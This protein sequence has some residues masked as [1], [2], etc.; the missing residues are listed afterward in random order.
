MGSDGRIGTVGPD[1]AVFFLSVIDEN[2]CRSAESEGRCARD[3]VDETPTGQ[4]L[5]S[6]YMQ[7]MCGREM[8]IRDQ[9]VSQQKRI[10]IWVGDMAR[11]NPALRRPHLRSR[12]HRLASMFRMRKGVP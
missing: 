4:R 9:W 10:S 5:P 11:M 1:S 7:C 8:P 12:R 6:L 2:G 3:R